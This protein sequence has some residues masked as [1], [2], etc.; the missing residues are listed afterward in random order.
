MNTTTYIPRNSIG[1]YSNAF[2]SK[3][4]KVAKIA[5]KVIVIVYLVTTLLL[6][7]WAVYVTRQHYV[8]HC[9][10]G[11]MFMTQQKCDDL[12]QSRIDS[13]EL[14]RLRITSNQDYK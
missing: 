6:S 1:Q 7:A 4:K 3:V 8:L 9:S 2:T 14:S 5:T 10:A 11:G 12:A 13:L